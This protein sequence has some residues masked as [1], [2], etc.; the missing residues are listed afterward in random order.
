[1]AAYVMPGGDVAKTASSVPSVY[2]APKGYVV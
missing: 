1:M 2:T